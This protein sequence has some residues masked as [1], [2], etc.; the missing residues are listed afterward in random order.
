MDFFLRFMIAITFFF[1]FSLYYIK[2]IYIIQYILEKAMKDKEL[3][4]G[5]V[6]LMYPS[7][8]VL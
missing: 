1:I 8:I 2:L 7:G 4:L 5:R 6:L 3:R